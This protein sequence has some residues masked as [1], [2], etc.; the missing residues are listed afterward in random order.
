MDGWMDGWIGMDRWIIILKGMDTQADPLRQ[1][2]G[3]S[4]GNAAAEPLKRAT[5]T[6]SSSRLSTHGTCACVRAR[7][8]M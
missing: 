4:L 7:V 6:S 3:A 8:P 2:A 1:H 5:R